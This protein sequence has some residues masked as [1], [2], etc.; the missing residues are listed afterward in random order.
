MK[1][2][3]TRYT[4]FRRLL[5]GAFLLG[6]LWLAPLLARAE[7]EGIVRY[8]VTQQAL[9]N[10]FVGGYGQN[11]Y[12]PVRLTGYQ[13]DYQ[14]D[15]GA[16]RYFTRWVTNTTG[17]GWQ[18]RSNRTLAEF[19]NLNGIFRDQGYVLVDVSGYQTVYGVRYAGIWH[20]NTDGLVW[21]TFPDVT[22]DGM[23]DLHDTIG[24]EG[25]R[26][27]RIEGYESGGQSRFISVWYYLPTVSYIWHSKMT[28][29]QYQDHVDDYLAAG[30]KPF[31]LHSHTQGGAVYFSAIWKSTSTSVRV[32]GNRDVR[33]FQRYYNNYWADGYNIDNF[34]ASLTP[35]GV[36]FGGIWFFDGET[37]VDDSS[38]L[39]LKARKEVDGAPALG[40]AAVLNLTTGD[41]YSIHGNQIFAIASTSKIGI[42]A[43][44]LKEI[45]E[46]PGNIVWAEF[47][48]S[49]LSTGATSCGNLKPNTEYRVDQLAAYMIRCSDNWATNV[50]IARLTL[51]TINQHLED[52]GLDVTRIHRYMIGGPSAHGNASASAD[53]AEGWENLST[54]NEMVEL[55]RRVLQDNVLSDD[56]ETR[57]WETLQL[58]TDVFPNTKNY[59]AAQVTPMFSPRINVYNKPGSLGDPGVDSRHVNAD[60]A[61]LSFPDGQEVLMAVFMDYVSDDPDEPLQVTRAEGLAVQAIK[62]VA[63]V[64]AEHYHP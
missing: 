25:W 37:P 61:R 56:G 17:K 39:S 48:N 3:I 47:V 54:P 20:R 43:A 1:N 10:E 5:S 24:Q 11:G 15:N 9:Q 45:D 12:L 52:L 8:G 22:M 62:N 41:S 16:T 19:N 64:V 55:L 14:V 30:F 57:F 34:Y 27:H 40:G 38:P 13:E 6:L 29:A 2:A 51:A 49:N 33:V 59:I 36:R 21:T 32:R 44:L 23:Q 4:I 42:L 50:L 18:V 63:K 7:E 28:E 46:N 35:D 31:H 58:D 26:P 60:A 53:R